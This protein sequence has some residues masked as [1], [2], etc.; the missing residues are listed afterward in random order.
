MRYVDNMEERLDRYEAYWEKKNHDRPILNLCAPNGKRGNPPEF[1]GT[2]QERWWDEDYI[3]SAARNS[4]ETTYYAAESLP[5]LCP[6]LGPDVFAAFLGSEIVYEE[7]TS[8]AKP[9]VEDWSQVHISF[10]ENN[11]YWQKICHMTEHFLQESR[12]D[13]LVGLTDLH[14]GMDALVSMRGPEAL[15]LDLYDDPDEVKRVLKEVQE[16]FSVILEKSYQ[17]FEGKQKGTTNWMGIYHPGRWYVSSSDF[18]Y[19]ISPEVFDEFSR[20]SIRREAQIIGNNIYHLDGIGS[21]RHLEKLLEMPEIHGI[22]WVYGAGQ[23][24]AAHWID[25]LKQIQDAGKLVE[26][27]CEPEDMKALFSCGLKPEGVR[28]SVWAK[29][30]EQADQI[31]REAEEAYKMTKIF[32]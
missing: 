10:D 11:A 8:Y 25:T 4:M 23:P 1:S 16:A 18:I 3:L 32:L 29:S 19:L 12:G 7:S 15:C 30:P 20:E 28:Y 6:N 5:I 26:I 31:V 27:N 17:L 9:F 24:T 22:Q 21:K 2:L 14:E 13:F